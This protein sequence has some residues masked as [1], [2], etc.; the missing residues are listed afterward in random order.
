MDVVILPKKKTNSCTK[1]IQRD[2]SAS[3]KRITISSFSHGSKISKVVIILELW[4]SFSSP[5]KEMAHSSEQLD[6][7]ESKSETCGVS[8]V[9]FT[10]ERFKLVGED[11]NLSSPF[12]LDDRLCWS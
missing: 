5:L 2:K 10:A 6:A 3:F 9:I 7:F 12:E 8:P 4:K 1:V 11:R